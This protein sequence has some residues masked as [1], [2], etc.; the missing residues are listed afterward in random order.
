[1]TTEIEIESVGP[2][3][4]GNYFVAN[5]PP[6]SVWVPSAVGAA[7][8]V[9][10]GPA[11]ASTDLGLYLHIPFCRK[12]C[13]FCYFKV[14]TDRSKDEISAYVAAL[15]R[16]MASYA[17]KPVVAGRAPAFLYFGGGTPSYLS[18][19]NL[20]HLGA[21]LHARF[22][23]TELREFTFE[24]EPGTLTPAKIGALRDIG[25]T[26]LSIGVESFDDRILE[27]NGRAHDSRQIQAAYDAAG[28]AGFPQINIDLI[29]GMVGETEQTWLASLDRTIEFRPDS[30]TI[31]Q[32]EVPHNTGLSAQMRG[33]GAVDMVADWPTKR[34]W[35]DHAFGE[36]ERA[37]YQVSSGYTMSRAGRDSGF[38]YRDSLWHGADLIGMGVSSFSHVG[39]VHFQNEHNLAEY[40]ARI[41]AGELPISR[42]LELSPGELLVREFILQLKLGRV[43][44]EYFHE[45]FAVDIF[46]EF[47]V[48]LAGLAERGMITITEDEVVLSR[49]ALLCVDGLL[50]AFFLPQHRNVRYT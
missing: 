16:E 8:R 7:H 25:V 32:M 20:R 30:V 44:Q 31:Y 50:P 35:V 33:Q 29:A 11:P 34:R 28:A 14:Y 19:R 18:V 9:L 48:P 4:V 41:Q 24:G 43:D 10:G 26:R 49:Q 15:V 5:Y 3:A 46:E 23:L 45:K 27:L 40:L 42:A 36:L 38:V 22:D 17:E 13:H 2:T 6:F 37:G 39:G 21:E 47:R 12:R 1:M